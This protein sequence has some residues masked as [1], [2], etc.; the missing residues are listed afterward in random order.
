MDSTLNKSN[1]YHLPSL[2]NEPMGETEEKIEENQEKEDEICDTRDNSE[3]NS[4]FLERTI[5]NPSV[6]NQNTQDSSESSNLSQNGFQYLSKT[7]GYLKKT[8]P[9]LSIDYTKS[10]NY[11]SKKELIKMRNSEKK[12]TNQ[13]KFIVIN[14][15]LKLVAVIRLN[16]FWMKLI[17]ID[18]FLRYHCTYFSS[19][20]IIS[21]NNTEKYQSISKDK[22]DDNEGLKNGSNLEEEEEEEK[23][24]K[25]IEKPIEYIKETKHKRKPYYRI[26]NN[27]SYG[28]YYYKKQKTY[29]KKRN[30]YENNYYK[31][32]YN[33]YNQPNFK[34]QN[35]FHK[36]E[37]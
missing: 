14:C 20:C 34:Y 35:R 31:P 37:Y 28:N 4:S 32:K 23:E 21:K 25:K 33:Y 27:R 5:S 19:E 13:T 10:K 6:L 17:Y 3:L 9:E 1:F 26:Y 18:P 7:I 22:R 36:Y 24:E 12:G 16:E 15:Q 29:N 30:Y 2:N 11:K 8:N